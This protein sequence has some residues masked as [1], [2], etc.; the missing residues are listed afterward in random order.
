M[1]SA[2]VWGSFDEFPARYGIARYRLVVFPPGISVSERRILRLWRAWPMWGAALWLVAQILGPLV[3]TPAAAFIGGTMLYIGMGALTFALA[4]DAR[5]QVR[6]MSAVR[7][8]GI[9][10]AETTQRYT[11]LRIL[12]RRLDRADLLVEEG[13]ISPAE[14]EAMWWQVY[15]AMVEQPALA[16]AR[17]LRAA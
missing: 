5:W 16:S 1:N 4:G 7:M 3:A 6:T 14:H 11:T 15:D 9:R 8:A 10:D 17:Q 13:R 2:R 12:A